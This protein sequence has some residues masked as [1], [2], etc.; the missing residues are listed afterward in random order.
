MLLISTLHK[1]QNI[2]SMNFES[3]YHA[4]NWRLK[5]NDDCMGDW[6]SNWL[7]DGLRADIDNTKEGMVFSAGPV[8]RDDA[9][10]A[11]LW[12]NQSFEGDVKIEYEYT[13]TDTRKSQVNILYIQATGVSPQAEDIESWSDARIIPSMSNYFNKMNALHISY[14]A[15]NDTIEYIRA[16]KYPRLPGQDFSTTTE[17]RPTYYNSGLFVP[18]ETYRITVIKAKKDL[19]FKVT[20]EED[21][22]LFAWSLK[23]DQMVS[24]GRIGLRH[25]YTRSARYKNF[26]VYAMK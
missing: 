7:L 13:R 3:L 17:I 16:R 5:F 19:F 1:G 23:E 11:V 8:E 4:D 15:F 18:G 26:K 25:M 21:S 12:T 24:Q 14:A 2:D 6:Q 20:G 22:K 10:H 9:C